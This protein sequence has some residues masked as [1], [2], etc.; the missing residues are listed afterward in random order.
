M[1]ND[2]NDYSSLNKANVYKATTDKGSYIVFKGTIE[3]FTTL[4]GG[5][6]SRKS[7]TH[8]QKKVHRSTQ[9]RNGRKRTN[10]RR[11]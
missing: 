2:K 3:D 8:R 10:H 11:K 7:K 4:S 9:K 1:I 5:K 6:K